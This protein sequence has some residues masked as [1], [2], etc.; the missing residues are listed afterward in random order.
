MLLLWKL[1]E[2]D[3]QYETVGLLPGHESTVVCLQFSPDSNLLATSGKDR[4]LCLYARSSA[5]LDH[6]VA[7]GNAHKRII[8]DLSWCPD[9]H[10]LVTASRDGS[11]KLWHP[12]VAGSRL[13]CVGSFMPF[14]SQPVTAIA[15]HPST[16]PLHGAEVWLMAVGAE[17]GHLQLWSLHTAKAEEYLPSALASVSEC[18]AHTKAV[19]RIR[20]RPAQEL[21]DV[22]DRIALD[23]A[24]CGDDHTVRIHRS[25]V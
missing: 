8:W 14:A 16:I 3:Q 18:Y 19:K 13:T 20:W 11:C 24:S 22:N 1:R 15:F 12:S 10:L 7:L 9:G 2:S 23:W 25:V 21:H 4:R 17:S 5:G 6:I